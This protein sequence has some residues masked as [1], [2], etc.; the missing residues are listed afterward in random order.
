MEMR[1]QR[2]EP[3]DKYWTSGI[4]SLPAHHAIRIFAVVLLLIFV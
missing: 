2:K 4:N 3:G 1:V